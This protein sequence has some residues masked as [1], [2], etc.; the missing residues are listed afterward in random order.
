MVLFTVQKEAK[1]KDLKD[2][3]S[4]LRKHLEGML[5]NLFLFVC[6]TMFKEKEIILIK[7]NV[8]PHIL[9]IETFVEIRA[10]VWLSGGR[11][12]IS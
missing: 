9:S 8:I 10:N 12:D 11:A 1:D 3:T 2:S 5:V 4:E 6:V 7:M